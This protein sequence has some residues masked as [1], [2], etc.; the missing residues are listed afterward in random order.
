MAGLGELGC[1]EVSAG[2]EEGID[3]GPVEG[4]IG[5]ECSW[6]REGGSSGP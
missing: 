1:V 5:P 4:D 6:L 2:L 3:A